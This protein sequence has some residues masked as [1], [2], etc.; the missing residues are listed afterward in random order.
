[1]H[2]QCLIGRASG[3]NEGRRNH[4]DSRKYDGEDGSTRMRVRFYVEGPRGKC[5]VWAEV[6]LTVPLL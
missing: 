4:V 2:L 6:S 5:L 1:M 3:R